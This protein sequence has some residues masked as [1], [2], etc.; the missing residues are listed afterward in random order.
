M[1]RCFVAVPLPDE[2]RGALAATVQAW[3]DDAIAGQLRWTAPE[4]WHLTLAFLGSTDPGAVPDL[5]EAL[6]PV[7][8]ATPPFAIGA[9]G[10]GTFPGPRRARVLWYA[11][12]DG[13]GALARLAAAVGAALAPLAPGLDES[14]PFRGHVTLARARSERGVDLQA[15]LE[16]QRVATGSVPVD[17]LVLYRSHLGGGPARYEA[18]GSVTLAGAAVR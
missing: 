9:G 8:E 5:L 7:A 4:G 16:Q 13:D 11:L 1:W 15:W 10:L 12:A 6:G 18:L 17:R 2:L 3:R 14:R